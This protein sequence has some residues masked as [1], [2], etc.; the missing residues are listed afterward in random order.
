MSTNVTRAT[1]TMTVE[2]TVPSTWGDETPV[3]QVR[4]QAASEARAMVCQVA[5]R[6]NVKIVGE[7]QVTALMVPLNNK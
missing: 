4:N 7:P 1:V 5:L 3:S 2:V 6:G